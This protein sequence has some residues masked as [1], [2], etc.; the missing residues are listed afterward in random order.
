M[1]INH[2]G[3]VVS[4]IDVAAKQ[5]AIF[6]FDIISKKEID[7][8]QAVEILFIKN[9]RNNFTLELIRPLHSKSPAYNFLKSGGGLNHICYEVVNIDDK[10][11]ELKSKGCKLVS[12]P[13]PA[14]VF[15]NNLVAFLYDKE[16]GLFELLQKEI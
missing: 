15:D 5:Y 16:I 10:I 1:K 14:I 3:V 12:K 13:K 9:S 4:N 2:I 7:D 11:R 8:I 6:G